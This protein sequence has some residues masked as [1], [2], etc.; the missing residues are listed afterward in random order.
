MGNV[1]IRASLDRA[2]LGGVADI[3]REYMCRVIKKVAV[4]NAD[5]VPV[6]KDAVT[7]QFPEFALHYCVMALEV[8][9]S[10]VEPLA[11]DCSI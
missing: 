6:S 4:L 11:K 10:A 1:A 3:F 9:E 7:M 5:G 2:S 8:C